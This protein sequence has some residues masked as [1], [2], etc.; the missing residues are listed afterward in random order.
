V[1]S[2]NFTVRAAPVEVAAVTAS[3][4][5]APDEAIN[6]PTPTQSALNSRRLTTLASLIFSILSV[7]LRRPF[8]VV[9]AN[10]GDSL[11]G[12]T[13]SLKGP[14]GKVR[15]VFVSLFRPGSNRF[16]VRDCS[17]L[18]FKRCVGVICD[19]TLEFVKCL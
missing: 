12:C 15:T 18:L 1:P 6:E 7:L 16:G 9:K 10:F 13:R 14:Q 5:D 8:S 19:A 11:L 17:N 2:R 3:T 4:A